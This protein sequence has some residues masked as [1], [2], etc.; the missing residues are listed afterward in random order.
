[1]NFLQI[2]L[3]KVDFL[4][5]PIFEKSLDIEISLS[6]VCLRNTLCSVYRVLGQFLGCGWATWLNF[7][8]Q[9]SIITIWAS[10]CH[11]FIFDEAWARLIDILAA[12]WGAFKIFLNSRRHSLSAS[13]RFC[14]LMALLS[15][16][17]RI[18]ILVFIIWDEIWFSFD[19]IYH[20]RLNNPLFIITVWR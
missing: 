17:K 18:F 5:E 13:D 19:Q 8:L 4:G 1:M 11:I 3:F 20:L 14:N 9:I 16:V 2:P 6:D 10:W 12:A 7:L 15:P